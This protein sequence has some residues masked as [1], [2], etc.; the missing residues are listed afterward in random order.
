MK[1]TLRIVILGMLIAMEIILTRFL[2]QHMMPTPY[3]RLSLGFVPIAIAGMLFGPLWGA[4][5]AAAADIVGANFFSPFGFFPGFTLTAAMTGAVYG[6]LLP[7]AQQHL[8][9]VRVVCA[10]F[11]VV[12]PVQLGIETYWLYLL[13]GRGVIAMMPMRLVRT[14]IMIVVQTGA[15]WLLT[16]PRFGSILSAVYRRPRE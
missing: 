7:R 13:Q 11:I 12:V 8:R 5:A 9:T 15:L 6:A 4:L 16:S 1:H 2:A 14:G 10:A 3:I